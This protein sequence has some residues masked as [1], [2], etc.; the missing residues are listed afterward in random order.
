MRGICHIRDMNAVALLPTH[1]L[2][3]QVAAAF[4]K[5]KLLSTHAIKEIAMHWLE[6]GAESLE[7]AALAGDRDGNFF[8]CSKLFE[9]CLSE[10]GARNSVSEKNSIIIAM[11]FLLGQIKEE[12][13]DPFIGVGFI[14]SEFNHEKYK[15]FQERDPRILK[16]A[17]CN[18]GRYAGQDVGIEYLLGMYY[19]QDD[20]ENITQQNIREIKK[21]LVEESGI[22]LTR[23]N[24]L[25][26]EL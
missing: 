10:M 24:L 1:D 26:L 22:V 15:L 13:I 7:V 6:G 19:S 16:P 8:E 12:K 11:R 5:L 14:I 21:A 25:K 9:R 3:P 2:D 4:W 20:Y 18:S 17:S 23:Y